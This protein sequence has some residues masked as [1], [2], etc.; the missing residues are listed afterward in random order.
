[1]SHIL[2]TH[3]HTDRHA[4]S[5]GLRVSICYMAYRTKVVHISPKAKK[6]LS[7]LQVPTSTRM[8]QWCFLY[9]A[10]TTNLVTSNG[11]LHLHKEIRWYTH[12]HRNVAIPDQI[13]TIS[14]PLCINFSSSGNKLGHSKGVV[15]TDSNKECCSSVLQGDEYRYHIKLR[16]LHLDYF[17]IYVHCIMCH[18][19][20]QNIYARWNSYIHN[21]GT[22]G[23]YG[24]GIHRQ[25]GFTVYELGYEEKTTFSIARFE[26]SGMGGPDCLICVCWGS[27]ARLRLCKGRCAS[28]FDNSGIVSLPTSLHEKANKPANSN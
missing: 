14:Y 10:S 20:P 9:F 12:V 7:N 24:N 23:N 13:S 19:A 27:F 21:Y 4:D 5:Y 1:M 28:G 8:S 3:T 6:E 11:I 15:G 2:D 22:E 17:P 16:T 18:L 26:C 25:H